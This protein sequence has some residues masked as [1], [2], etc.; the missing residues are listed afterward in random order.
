MN[1]TLDHDL[2]FKREAK[3]VNIKIVQYNLYM[4]THNES[5]FDS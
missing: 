3:T 1:D 5:G 2:S 4:I